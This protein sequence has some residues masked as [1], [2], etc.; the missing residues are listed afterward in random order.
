MPQA[1]TSFGGSCISIGGRGI[2]GFFRLAGGGEDGV[3][4][5]GGERAGGE[6]PIR[7]DGVPERV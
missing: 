6:A 1:M 3:W 5:D 2:C 4:A 7:V